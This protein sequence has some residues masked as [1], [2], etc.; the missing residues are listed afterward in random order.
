MQ[1]TFASLAFSFA[2]RYLWLIASSK[3][4][5]DSAMTRSAG[6]HHITA[7]SSDPNRNVAFYRDVLGLR[8]VKKTV[9][10]DDPST[11]HLYFG[12]DTGSPGTLLTFFYWDGMGRGRPGAGNA[13]E[14]A[15]AIPE[16][17][18]G[19]WLE[20]FISL[21]IDHD[22]PVKRFGETVIAFRDP[23]GM[24]I[25]LVATSTFGNEGAAAQGGVPAAH[26][27]RGF[28]GVTLW[29]DAEK[30]SAAVLERVFG[31]ERKAEEPNRIRYVAPGDAIGTRIDIRLVTGFPRGQMGVGTIHHVAFRA[32]DDAAQADMAEGL[33][34]LGIGATEQ[35]DRNYFR[36]I[37]FREP[38]GIIF[39]I[40]TDAPGMAI[41]EERIGTDIK[42]PEQF[43]PHRA[44]ILAALP[45]L[46]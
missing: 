4:A 28:A 45:A 41:D 32:A 36:S 25:E 39:E 21:G 20:R 12:D 14:I 9:N 1:A 29:A 46:D 31:Y 35:K 10:F 18:T 3:K 15:F 40:A 42:L 6:I 17:A 23:D 19:F 43:E 7:I 16:A 2:R 8:L 34:A 22:P 44:K 26:A 37:Y 38:A 5:K 33:R 24:H 30:P 11:Y 27:I 13:V